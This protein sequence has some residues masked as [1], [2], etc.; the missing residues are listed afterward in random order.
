MADAK[1]IE[2]ALSG[3]VSKVLSQ[4]EGKKKRQELSSDEDDSVPARKRFVL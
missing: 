3:A 4:L 2:K 1:A